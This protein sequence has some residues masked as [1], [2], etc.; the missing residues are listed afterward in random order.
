M[1]RKLDISDGLYEFLTQ[2]RFQSAHLIGFADDS[3]VK[4]PEGGC[5]K[6]VGTSVVPIDYFLNNQPDG[7]LYRNMKVKRGY[8]NTIDGMS[9]ALADLIIDHNDSIVETGNKIVVMMLCT[10]FNTDNIQN[11]IVQRV[12]EKK[13]KGMPKLMNAYGKRPMNGPKEFI[14][15]QTVGNYAQILYNKQLNK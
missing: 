3:S 6:I 8:T 5:T 11:A 10:A 2:G 1:V 9:Q 12:G 4:N 15:K 14:Y 13:A 7:V